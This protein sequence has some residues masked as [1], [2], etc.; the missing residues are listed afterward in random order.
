M[1]NGESNVKL[2]RS[3]RTP[4]KKLFFNDKY[5]SPPKKNKTIR[6]SKRPTFLSGSTRRSLGRSLKS[7][8]FKSDKTLKK[9]RSFF[10]KSLRKRRGLTNILS[11]I[12]GAST[13]DK[14]NSKRITPRKTLERGTP[15]SQCNSVIGSIT[16]ETPYT[17]KKPDTITK[18]WLCGLTLIENEGHKPECE[19]ILPIAEAAMFLELHN[20]KREYSKLVEKEYGWSHQICNRVKGDMF[21]I[22]VYDNKFIVNENMIKDMLSDIVNSGR[23][24]A[25]KLRRRILDKYHTKAK[26]IKLRT[27]AIK[28]VYMGIINTIA[29]GERSQVAGLVTLASASRLFNTRRKKGPYAKG[30]L[31]AIVENTREEHKDASEPDR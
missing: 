2:T 26:F 12:H 11:F 8:G 24:Y 16:Y 13:L 4:I 31:N 22:S 23:E 27:D 6:S 19:H 25:D 3:G 7:L 9:R 15:D 14:L 5:N 30:A 28:E 1:E 17:L 20:S 21:P 29:S 18:C 10:P